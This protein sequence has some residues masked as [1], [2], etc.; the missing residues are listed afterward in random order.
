MIR[1][2][3][4]DDQTLVRQ[5]VKSL[6][7]LAEDIQIVGEA[8]DGR[9]AVEMIPELRP[10]VVALARRLRRKRPK[11]GQRSLRDVAAELAQRG[12][13]NEQGRPFSAAS[14]RSMLVRPSP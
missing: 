2:C 3:L 11:G 10:D 14:A 4:V 1:V 7:D 8:S 5:G 6:L 12:H 9:Q 13:L